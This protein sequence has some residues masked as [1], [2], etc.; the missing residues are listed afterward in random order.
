VAYA[1]QTLMLLL[2]M[3]DWRLDVATRAMPLGI[4][5]RVDLL[6]FLIP[7]RALDANLPPPSTPRHILSIAAR[8]VHR[9]HQLDQQQHLRRPVRWSMQSLPMHHT[10]AASTKGCVRFV[11]QKNGQPSSTTHL[12]KRAWAA[13]AHHEVTAVRTQYTR[14][15]L[16]LAVH[17]PLLLGEPAVTRRAHAHSERL[18][19]VRLVEK[20]LCAQSS[21]PT[22]PCRVMRL[23]P[24]ARAAWW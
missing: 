11:L 3:L 7:H 18:V 21:R 19:G 13:V 6:P 17:C 22:R 10:C 14:L 9:P 12:T 1:Q 20:R 23:M 8:W 16:A 2:E 15:L 5:R 4:G 24:P